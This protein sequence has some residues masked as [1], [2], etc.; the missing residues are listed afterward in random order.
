MRVSI[1]CSFLTLIHG[2]I[3]YTINPTGQTVWVPLMEE[4]GHTPSIASPNLIL[5]G[6][7]LNFPGHFSSMCF[8]ALQST[9]IRMNPI[10]TPV[11]CMPVHQLCKWL[12]MKHSLNSRLFGMW[13]KTLFGT[14]GL[15][16]SVRYLFS[17][18]TGHSCLFCYSPLYKMQSFWHAW[19]CLY[20]TPNSTN[21]WRAS[22][23]V[24]GNT[25]S[26]GNILSLSA[27]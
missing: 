21:N 18:H 8:I 26:S 7:S 19:I 25:L 17:L 2:G 23:P 11:L 13:H 12:A 9:G 3:L 14:V 24:D 16:T 22:L 10:F 1:R 27:L 15:C 20:S 5:R 4:N 6:S